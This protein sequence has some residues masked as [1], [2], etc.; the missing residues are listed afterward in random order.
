MLEAFPPRGAIRLLEARHTRGDRPPIEALVGEEYVLDTVE[1]FEADRTECAKRLAAGERVPFLVLF[2]FFGVFFCCCCCCCCVVVVFAFFMLCSAL[3]LISPQSAKPSCLV[4]LLPKLRG[5][6]LPFLLNP[7]PLRYLRK[8]LLCLL[9]GFH[10]ACLIPSP[11]FLLCFLPLPSPAKPCQ[12]PAAAP[13]SAP[14]VIPLSLPSSPCP[15][16]PRAALP[17]PWPHEPL[18]CEVL[19]GQL[20][21]IPRPAHKPVFTA[22]LMVDLCKLC[23]LF[24]RA[25]SACVRWGRL[26]AGSRAR[27]LCCWLACSLAGWLACVLPCLDASLLS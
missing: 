13:A 23:K 3:A 7:L 24:P 22:A 6:F 18:L 21:R 10:G 8:P 25:M 12:A 15:P 4:L 5:S 1:A 16:F 20:L 11:P 2:L 9:A 27:L 17:L 19:F 26:L 14:A